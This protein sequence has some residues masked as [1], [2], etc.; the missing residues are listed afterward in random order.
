LFTF[1]VDQLFG[2]IFSLIHP[3]TGAG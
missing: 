2:W 3:A 1:I